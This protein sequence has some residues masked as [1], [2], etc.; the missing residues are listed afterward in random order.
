MNALNFQTR[1]I[2]IDTSDNINIDDNGNH[3]D[4]NDNVDNEDYE[5]YLQPCPPNPP[6]S[7][8][9]APTMLTGT[10]LTSIVPERLL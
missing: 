9:K 8:D 10:I 5:S 2:I 3:N 1:F 4:K 6:R 7:L